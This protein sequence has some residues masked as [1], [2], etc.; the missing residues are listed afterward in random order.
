MKR[1]LPPNGKIGKDAKDTVQECVSEFISFITSEASD[2]CQKEKRKTVNGDNKGSGKSGDGFNRDAAEGVSELVRRGVASELRRD[3]RTTPND[4]VIPLS[5]TP[6]LE[7]VDFSQ[8]VS[9]K[10]SGRNHRRSLAWDSAFFTTL[11]HDSL[12]DANDVTIFFFVVGVLDHEE[13]FGSLKL[14]ENEIDVSHKDL[15][16]KTLPFVSSDIA[17]RPSFVWDNAFLTEPG[18]LDAEELSLLNNGFIS[19]T[20]PR[21]SADSMTTTTEGS[22]FSVSSIELDL[23]NDLRASSN[24]KETRAQEIQRKLPDGNKRTK[25]YKLKSQRLSLIP[26]PKAYTPP[27]SS[28][29][30]SVSESF[31]P[32][33]A[34]PEKKVVASEL[35]NKGSKS[36]I[37]SSYSGYKGKDLTSSSSGLRLP[38]PKMGFFDSE[39]DGDKENIEPNASA[40]RRR[41][42]SK[43]GTLYPQ[44][45]PNVLGQRKTR[46]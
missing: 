2:K 16:K 42:K 28:F 30:S 5:I 24:V 22:R 35:G 8:Q 31:T 43:L 26:Q 20:Q 23:F 34:K 36:I 6:G 17:T 12:Y 18:V 21:N 14:G 10:E 7:K 45:T 40:N 15:I 46:K 33:Q 3:K 25:W 41:H 11:K 1:A 38:L 9:D 29:S 32:R 39:N 37:R 27:S 44:E 19:N 13:L 4:Q